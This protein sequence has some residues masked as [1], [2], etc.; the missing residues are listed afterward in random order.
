[1]TKRKNLEALTSIRGIAALLVVFYHYQDE[2]APIRLSDYTFLFEKGYLWVDLFFVLSGFVIT[3]SHT[4]FFDRQRAFRRSNIVNF[5][6]LRLARVWPLHMFVLLLFLFKELLKYP[7]PV[8]GVPFEGHN[9]IAAFITNVFL[10]HAWAVHDHLSWNHPS[11][12]ISVE[13]A[14]Y[15]AYPL[16]AALLFARL[17]LNRAA[18]VLLFVIVV[19]GAYWLLA[20]IVPPQQLNITYD[21]GVLRG[22]VSFVLGGV[23]YLAY[24]RGL[25]RDLDIRAR[26]LIVWA[27]ALWSLTGMALDWPD[28]LIVSTFPP[29]ILFLAYEGTSLNRLLEHRA[30][31][32]L[33]KISYSV[34]MVHVIVYIV[35]YNVYLRA[36]GGL[37]GSYL[38]GGAML[39]GAVLAT[40]VTSI[41][42]FRFVE[43]PARD[44]VRARMRGPATA[45]AAVAARP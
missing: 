8:L 34:Y 6:I 9:T 27:A 18:M 31:T 38:W 39:V 24:D 20:A 3:Y 35:V 26:A 5:M 16:I 22:L 28:F 43:K 21:Y 7:L 1:M 14:C 33:G 37:Q 19:P 36:P 32:F 42:T 2:F 25:L 17:Q 4:E 45:A 15:L 13:W 29:L 23:L 40:I 12:S 30:F 11:W 10:V 44:W 41:L